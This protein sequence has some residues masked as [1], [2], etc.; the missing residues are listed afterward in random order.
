VALTNDE[1]SQLAAG[2]IARRWSGFSLPALL[3]VR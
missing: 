1:F 3:R 2:Q